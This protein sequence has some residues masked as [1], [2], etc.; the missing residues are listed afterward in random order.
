[1]KELSLFLVPS[2]GYNIYTVKKGKY[3]D[4][5]TFC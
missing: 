5:A 1:M 2:L 3:Q 4:S